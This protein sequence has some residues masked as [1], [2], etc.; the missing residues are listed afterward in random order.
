M[1][2]CFF[3]IFVGEWVKGGEL[4]GSPGAAFRLRPLAGVSIVVNEV[5][6]CWL[7][8]LRVMPESPRESFM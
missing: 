8:V 1:Y 7:D 6:I 3:H 2:E 5:L 4:E